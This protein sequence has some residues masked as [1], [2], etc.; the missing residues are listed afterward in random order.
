M[1]PATRN[2]S[3]RIGFNYDPSPQ[4]RNRRQVRGGF[5]LFHGRTPYV[6]LSNQYSNTG[7]EFQRIRVFFDPDNRI[8]FSADPDAQPTG[9]GSASTNEI[10]LIDPAYRFRSSCAAISG[11][12]ATS[13]SSAWW[14]ASSCF[15][16]T[17]RDIDYRDLNLAASRCRARRAAEAR[18][19]AQR[20]Q[21]RH[22][23][24]E[25]RA[26][27]QLELGGEAR[28]A[29]RQQLVPE[30][31]VSL[32]RVA[33]RQ[34]RRVEPGDLQL[35]QQLP[36]RRPERGAP[37]PCRTSHR[38]IGSACRARTGFPRGRPASPS[39]PTTTP[40]RAAPTATWTKATA[41]A[42]ARGGTTSSTSHATPP[43]SSS[44]TG[45]STT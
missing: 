13:A 16:R 19:P 12:T 36:R 15:S 25:H 35:A 37:R 32:R 24:H 10:N 45:P 43:T 28:Q 17:V 34:R 42:T 31:I 27:R 22:P 1:A 18:P 40:S 20:L 41:T 39:P 5:G 38:A 44:P 14:G 23:A 8:P 7:N 2:W 29:V 11:T 4:S 26:G 6:W 33:V 21:Q 9:V 30:R 3:P